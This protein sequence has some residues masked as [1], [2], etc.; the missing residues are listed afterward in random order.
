[1]ENEI[2]R[3]DHIVTLEMSIH[4]KFDHLFI[5]F[6]PVAACLRPVSSTIIES[7][8]RAILIHTKSILELVL[9]G[10]LVG[11]YPRRSPSQQHMRDFQYLRDT[12]S[13]R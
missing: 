10:Y 1:M 12:T 6:K 9:G 11:R 5:W 3:L 13:V 4:A 8:Y 7:R 2:H